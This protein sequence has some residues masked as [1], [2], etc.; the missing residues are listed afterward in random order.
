MYLSTEIEIY[1]RERQIREIEASFEAAKSDPV[2]ATNK[3]LYPVE[4]MPLLPDFD[5]YDTIYNFHKENY[6]S[7]W[8]SIDRSFMLVIL[9][10]NLL[11]IDDTYCKT[12]FIFHNN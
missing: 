4:I 6:C 1:F 3:D 5:R 2:H 12:T 10:P 7:P 9:K 11:I 8:R